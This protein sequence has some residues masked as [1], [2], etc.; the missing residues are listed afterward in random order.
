MTLR[1]SKEERDI[2]LDHLL[3]LND[4]QFRA[5]RIGRKIRDNFRLRGWLKAQ[6]RGKPG[7]KTKDIYE[8]ILIEPEQ[9]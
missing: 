9:R 2:W 4:R 3:N 7:F 5:N 1:W 6:G 8:E